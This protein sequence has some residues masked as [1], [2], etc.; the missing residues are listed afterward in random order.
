MSQ[1][2]LI[3]LSI[4]VSVCIILLVLLILAILRIKS[5]YPQAVEVK[6]ET[7]HKILKVGNY[8][9][10]SQ[11]SPSSN[12]KNG[13]KCI[14]EVNI[15]KEENN[16][17]GFNNYIK[18]YDLKTNQLHYTAKRTGLFFYK[19]NQ[20]NNLFRTTRSYINDRIVSQLYGYSIKNKENKITF[21]MNGNWHVDNYIYHDIR[22]TLEIIDPKRFKHTC[23]HYNP[24]LKLQ[25]T[26]SEDYSQ[27]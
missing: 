17:I 10:E 19:V 4:L 6:P 5:L 3:T 25:F 11:I 2:L 18:A 27:Q 24:W 12:F 22:S 20:G 8:K 9:G 16:N 26:I 15:F 21:F 14:H 23:E 7:L 13:L 1:E